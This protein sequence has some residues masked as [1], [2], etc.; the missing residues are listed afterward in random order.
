MR[1]PTALSVV[2]AAA[3]AAAFCFATP[4]LASNSPQERPPPRPVLGAVGPVVDPSDR[5]GGGFRRVTFSPDGDGRDDVVVIR[6]RVTPGDQLSLLVRPVSRRSVYL[7]LPA[8]ASPL[9]TVVWNGLRTTGARYP[10]GSYILHVCDTTKRLCS[11]GRVLAH[12]RVITVFARR[13]TGVSAGDTVRVSI[14]TDRLGPY[15]LDL[16]SAADATGPGLGSVEVAQPG[17]IDYRVPS[18]PH[19]GLWLLR[20]RDGPAL[21][22]FPLVVHEPTLPLGDPPPHT[23]LVVYPWLTWRAYDM[24]DGNRDGQVDSWYAH[25][26]DPVVPLYGPFEPATTVPVLEGREPNPDSQAAFA[27]WLL[28]HKLTAQHVTDVELGRMPASVLRQYA[29]VVFEGHTEYYERSTY[30]MLLRYR[31]GG[32]RLYFLQGNS[33]YGEARIRGSSVTRLSYRFRT[34]SRSDFRLAVTGFRV[35]CWPATIRPVYR[36][37]PGAVEAI[38]WAFAGTSLR[39]GDSLGTADGEVDTVDPS[40]SP[41]GTLTIATATVPAFTPTSL[42]RETPEAYIGTTPFPF[43]PAWKHPRRIAIAYAATGNGEVFSWGS[44][45]FLETVRFGDRRLPVTERAALDRVALN[46]WT[47]FER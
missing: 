4:A 23:A 20:V 30:D 37:A 42:T 12:L 29:L 36:L 8:A 9:T 1:C 13:A 34:P 26:T 14:A 40:L 28:D 25:P 33:F 6:A 11:S 5:E 7:P 21:A 44:T 15:V 43:E 39:D 18:V 41:A 35:C 22:H 19:G 31:D 46:V 32:G 2:P 38:P 47:H 16:V 3:A 10:D 45:G 27:G 17:W 24:F